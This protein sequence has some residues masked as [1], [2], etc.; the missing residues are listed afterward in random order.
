MRQLRSQ[1]KCDVHAVITSRH[2]KHIQ[3]GYIKLTFAKRTLLFVRLLPTG[4]RE[5]VQIQ[6]TRRLWRTKYLHCRSGLGGRW[7]K[8]LQSP[9]KEGN[10]CQ[11]SPIYKVYTWF[12]T[13]SINCKT[14]YTA[15][16]ETTSLRV[17]TRSEYNI[18]CTPT[19]YIYVFSVAMQLKASTS[20]AAFLFVYN[21]D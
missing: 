3:Y 7:M 5:R 13:K 12:D 10:S 16:K 2:Y 4:D 19:Y 17:T 15:P 20:C 14:D 1:Q 11:T 9:R 18:Y 6:Q 21:Y 8:A